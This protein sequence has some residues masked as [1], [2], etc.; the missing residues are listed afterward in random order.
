MTVDRVEFNNRRKGFRVSTASGRYWFPYARLGDPVAPGDRVIRAWVD[1]EIGGDG[2]SY[3]LES[4]S[5]GT[6]HIDSVLEYNR[7]PTHVRD[8]LLYRLTLEA[9]DRI[10]KAGLS[11]RE[12]VRRLKTSPAQLYRLLDQTNY[13]KSTDQMLSLLTVLDCSV[14]IVV[15]PRR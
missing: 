3:L 9:Q 5:E 11:R 4:G 12:V 6:V 13:R 1:E 8:M 15:S 2:F 10:E 7:D 14:D